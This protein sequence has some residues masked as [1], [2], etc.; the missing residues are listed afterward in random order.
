MTIEIQ[1]IYEDDDAGSKKRSTT[2]KEKLS[3]Y[4]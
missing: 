2:E 4:L 1:R 3:G